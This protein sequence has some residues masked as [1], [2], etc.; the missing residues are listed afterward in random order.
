MYTAQIIYQIIFGL[1]CVTADLPESLFIVMQKAGYSNRNHVLY[2]MQEKSTI[3]C[4][5]KK[6]MS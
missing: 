2:K 5:S 6:K 3:L 4:Y 1:W